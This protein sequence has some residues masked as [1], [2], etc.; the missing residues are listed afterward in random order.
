MVEAI[1]LV[2]GTKPQALNTFGKPIASRFT[3]RTEFSWFHEHSS[4]LLRAIRRGS[5]TSHF[6]SHVLLRKSEHLKRISGSLLVEDFGEV[7][8]AAIRLR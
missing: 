3:G 1:L 4:T 8:T 5:P 7:F 2:G 6:F